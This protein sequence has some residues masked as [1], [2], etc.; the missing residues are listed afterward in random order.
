[1]TS[2]GIITND[3]NNV[4]L[5]LRR[6][7][8]T[9][10]PPGGGLEFG[11]LPPEGAV[12]EV[13][14]ESG[15]EAV[16]DRLVGV[17]YWP[18]EPHPFLTFSFRC[19]PTGGRLRS[20][21]ETAKAAFYPTV[22]L[23]RLMVPFHRKR[24]MLGLAHTNGTPYWGVQE[25]NWAED[26]G[27]RFLGR[28][29][30][31]LEKLC[32]LING[33]LRNGRF[34]KTSKMPSW[35]MGAFVVIENDEGA[36]LWVKRTDYDVWNLPG[37]GSDEG[38]PP[39][40]TAVREAYEETGLHVRLTDISGVYFYPDKTHVIF[41]FTAV[42]ESGELT[43][44]PE[45]AAFDYFI[46]TQEPENVVTQH[47]ERTVDATNPNRNKTIFKFQSSQTIVRQMKDAS[48]KFARRK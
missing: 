36:V 10:A 43:T 38:E 30:Y 32:R 15:I 37:G 21:D 18:N 40:E 5:I 12:R 23:P 33:R 11:E 16:P 46:P 26:L 3:R 20:S 8:R 13:E 4:L 28:V 22:P 9:L 6:D 29:Y 44:G 34:P 41:T 45:A 48:G 1:M 7:T 14:E 42:I 24:V 35:D 25:M 27:K 2:N 17:Y 39:W 47:V 19:T 31:P